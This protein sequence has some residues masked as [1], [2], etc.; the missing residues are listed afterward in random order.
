MEEADGALLVGFGLAIVGSVQ[1]GGD[2]A[3]ADETTDGPVIP[4]A[5]GY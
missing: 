1:A 5:A 2:F 3:V 4:V